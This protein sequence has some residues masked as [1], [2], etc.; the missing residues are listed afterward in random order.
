[1]SQCASH[2]FG[3]FISCLDSHDIGAYRELQQGPD[4]KTLQQVWRYAEFTLT[5]NTC[6]HKSRAMQ[7]DVAAKVDELLTP[8]EVTEELKS[9]RE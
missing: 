8:I 2:V 9:L 7:A 5:L 4:L 3:V 6:A 1:M